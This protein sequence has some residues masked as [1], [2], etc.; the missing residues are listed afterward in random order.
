MCVWV[1]VC[2][3]FAALRAKIPDLFCCWI[4]FFSALFLFFFLSDI[5]LTVCTTVAAYCTE[6]A[7]AKETY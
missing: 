1:C 5:S 2:L 7:N 3:L 6:T 4:S